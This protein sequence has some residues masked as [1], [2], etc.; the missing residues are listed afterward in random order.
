V[1]TVETGNVAKRHVIAVARED[2]TFA[3]LDP[4]TDLHGGNQVVTTGHQNLQDGVKVS[5]QLP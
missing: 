1:Y 4:S 2:D 3:Q 5:V